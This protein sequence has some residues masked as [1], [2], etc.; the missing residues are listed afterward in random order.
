MSPHPSPQSL[1]SFSWPY[2]YPIRYTGVSNELPFISDHKRNTNVH[3]GLCLTRWADQCKALSIAITNQ[4]DDAGGPSL[5]VDFK[6]PSVSPVDISIHHGPTVFVMDHHH[7]VWIRR[8]HRGSIL[9]MD[10]EASWITSR[11][12]RSSVF[13]MVHQ[14]SLQG[15]AVPIMDMNEYSSW[16]VSTRCGS[17]QIHYGSPACIRIP[18][19]CLM[20]VPMDAP[21]VYKWLNPWARRTSRLDRKVRDPLYRTVDVALHTHIPHRHQP[22]RNDPNLDLPCWTSS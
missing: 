7:S 20:S 16:T 10:Q 19:D 8:T 14:Y 6:D 13:S 12:L 3:V 1:S 5:Q 11:H 22:T 4:D 21:M 18:M 15:S 9:A 17:S 2:G